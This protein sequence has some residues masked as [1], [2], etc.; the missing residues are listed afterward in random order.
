MSK[1]VKKDVLEMSKLKS[2]QTQTQIVT[3]HN[4]IQKYHR[5][6]AGLLCRGG[7][8]GQGGALGHAAEDRLQQTCA[9][10]QC[11]IKVG[12]LHYFQC[13]FRVESS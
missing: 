13:L 8:G 12:I 5:E 4:T 11:W 7:D 1:K 9:C 10:K 2:V 6:H 3:N